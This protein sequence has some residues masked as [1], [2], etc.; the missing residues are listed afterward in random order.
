L[1]VLIFFLD[2][3]DF[4]LQFG[5]NFRTFRQDCFSPEWIDELDFSPLCI[6]AQAFGLDFIGA[7]WIA[8]DVTSE[9]SGLGLA[10]FELGAGESLNRPGVWRHPA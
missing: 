3:G 10:G 6:V 7:V 8:Q 9:A 5:F 4:R 1:Q 2:V